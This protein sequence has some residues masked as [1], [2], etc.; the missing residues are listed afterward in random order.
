MSDNS[1]LFVD[2]EQNVLNALERLFDDEEFR[3]LTATNG[4]DALELVKNE[5]IA[6]IVSDN[7]MPGMQGV[8]FLA[9]ARTISP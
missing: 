7:C 6:V 5:N 8:K 3:I 9:K 2:D 4:K 1:V